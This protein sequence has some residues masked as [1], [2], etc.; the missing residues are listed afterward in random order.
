MGPA[1][2]YPLRDST[3]PRHTLGVIAHTS[4]PK[5]MTRHGLYKDMLQQWLI[6]LGIITL[7]PSKTSPFVIDRPDKLHL[8]ESQG[9]FS[10]TLILTATS[11]PPPN[12]SLRL[13]NMLLIFCLIPRP[14][15]CDLKCRWMSVRILW[16]SA[17]TSSVARDPWSSPIHG[18]LH[19][20]VDS[21][22]SLVEENPRVGWK[23][24]EWGGSKHGKRGQGTIIYFFML[25]LIKLKNPCVG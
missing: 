8:E 21:V 18:S 22:T 25:W 11:T 24:H 10:C 14:L 4:V 3:Y 13:I 23:F 1:S 5:K 2:K 6:L 17:A 16:S 15:N 12:I 9:G 19:I 7:A 20:P